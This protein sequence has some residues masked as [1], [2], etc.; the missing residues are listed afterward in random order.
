MKR[1]PVL[2]F[3]KKKKKKKTEDHDK[4]RSHG[5]GSKKKRP[6]AERLIMDRSRGEKA[7]ERAKAAIDGAQRDIIA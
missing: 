5:H 1:A 4:R 7:R 6:R 2:A 3:K